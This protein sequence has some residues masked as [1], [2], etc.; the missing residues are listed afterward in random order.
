MASRGS[1]F[2]LTHYR[3]GYVVI[4]TAYRPGMSLLPDQPPP[5]SPPEKPKLAQ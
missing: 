4:V 2:K 5:A 1:N 3:V